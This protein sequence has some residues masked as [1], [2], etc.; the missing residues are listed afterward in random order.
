M[1]KR[2][3]QYRPLE[4]IGSVFR[5]PSRLMAVPMAEARFEVSARSFLEWLE[6]SGVAEEFLEDLQCLAQTAAG[7]RLLTSWVSWD[8]FWALVSVAEGP[9]AES[10]KLQV[11][12]WQGMGLDEVYFN[13]YAKPA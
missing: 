7:E 3:D 10:L 8:R 2:I 4:I 5:D 13:F 9:F 11:Q 6:A 12:G 1:S